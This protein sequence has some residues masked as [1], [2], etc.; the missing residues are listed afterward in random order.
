MV[1]SCDMWS[2]TSMGTYQSPTEIQTFQNDLDL[3]LYIMSS[4][5]H[6]IVISKGNGR[7]N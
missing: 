6:E 3:N 4:I 2:L 7:K 1:L 5:S